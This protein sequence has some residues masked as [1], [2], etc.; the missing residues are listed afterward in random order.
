MLLQVQMF[1][2]FPSSLVACADLFWDTMI[3]LHVIILLGANLGFLTSHLTN[4]DSKK[5]K[6][7]Q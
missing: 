2:C 3:V 7:D 5:I 1:R 6:Q 4:Q